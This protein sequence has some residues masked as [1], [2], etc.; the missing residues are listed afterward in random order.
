[1]GLGVFGIAEDL[2]DPIGNL[3]HFSFFH[4]TCGDGWR[5]DANSSSFEGGFGIEGDAVFVY[6]D[7]CFIEGFLSDFSVEAVWPKVD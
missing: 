1:M 5:S 2:V 6:C 4:A 3:G 7:T